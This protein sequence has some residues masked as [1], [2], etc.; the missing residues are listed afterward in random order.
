MISNTVRGLINLALSNLELGNPTQETINKATNYLKEAVLQIR[1]EK[2]EVEETQEYKVWLFNGVLDDN[3]IEDSYINCKNG[4]IGTNTCYRCSDYIEIPEDIKE[5]HII[6]PICGSVGYNVGAFY[7]ENKT[8]LYGVSRTDIGVKYAFNGK[9]NL[10]ISLDGNEK[11]FIVGSESNK[12]LCS[13]YYITTDKA[14]SEKTFIHESNEVY[15]VDTIQSI[16]SIDAKT[17][18]TVITR[19]YC[20]IGDGGE[21][22]YDIVSYEEFNYLL[23]KDIQLQQ[24]SQSLI[25]TP[26]DEFGNHTLNNGLV[27]KLKL[28]GETTPEQWGAK[29]DGIS[30]DCQAFTHMFAQIKTGKIIFKENATYSLG[31]IYKEDTISS[32]KDNPYKGYMCGNLLGGQLYGKP[33]MANIKDVEFV[34]NN[35]KIELLND[36]FG[37]SGMGLLNFAGRVEGLKI[38]DLRFDGKGR[39]LFSKTGNKNSNHTLFYSPSTFAS[40]SSLIKSIHPLYLEKED[41]FDSGYFKNVEINNCYFYD[42]GAMHRKAGDWGGDFILVINPTVMDNVNIHHNKF[43]AWGRWVFAIDL[44]GNGECLKNIKFN[45]NI[46]IGANAYEEVNEDGSYKFLIDLDKKEFLKLNPGYNEAGLDRQLDLWRW[47]ALGFIDFEAKKCFENVEM[48]GNT[49]IGSGGWAINGNSRVSKNFLI[50]DNR[51]EHVGGG[52]PYGFELYSGMSSDITFENNR[53]CNVSVKP[54]YFTNNFTFINNYMTSSIRTFGLAG[55]IRM[56]NNS[57]YENSL[58]DLWSHESNNYYDDFIP[59]EKAKED[60]IKVIFKNNDCF[61]GANFN[62][63]VEPEKDMAEYFD[64]ELEHSEIRKAQITAFNSN[65]AIDFSKLKSCAQPLFFHG[66]KSLSPYKIKDGIS[67]VY[68]EK[69]QKVIESL[70]KMGV[71]GGKAFKE[72]F[73]ENFNIYNSCNWSAYADRN[74]YTNIDLV[75]IE[76]GHLFGCCEYGFRNQ[77]THVKYLLNGVKAQDDAYICTDEDIY[78]TKLGGKLTQVPTHKEGMVTYTDEEGNNI[79]LYYIGKLGKFEL[80]CE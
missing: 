3:Y 70:N 41:N 44:G 23:P 58:R 67:S 1:R 74:N 79:D 24:T 65:L 73:I 30:N 19:G 42:A 69:G 75:C 47:R 48:I 6:L 53:L 64:F 5:L 72:D 22:V 45:N 71:L 20:T 77:C 55:T 37:S 61:F 32:F 21:A 28:I 52:Y 80:K 54:G 40:K 38:H 62:N 8:Y 50:K 15:T 76:D 39:Y 7:D 35:A 59:M 57:S 36:Q 68:F 9:E 66:V 25:E 51:W 17:G 78:W 63:F 60:R 46:C 16:N 18:D 11:Y 56:E 31:M 49:I 43:E 14:K 26:V 33:I 34:G 29:G 12:A 4:K 27:A 2:E 13:V 10:T